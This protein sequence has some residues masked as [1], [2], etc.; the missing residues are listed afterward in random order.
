MV[1]QDEDEEKRARDTALRYLSFR[2]RSCQQVLDRLRYKGF[3][4]PIAEEVV[5]Y[6]KRL[7]YLNDK[8]L[9]LEVAEYLA[10]SKKVGRQYLIHQ[11]RQRGVA[12]EIIEVVSGEMFASDREEKELALQL[13]QKRIAKYRHL[14]VEKRRSRL[15]HLL[16]RHGFCQ[17]TI[18]EV[19]PGVL[20]QVQE[21]NK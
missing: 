10:K 21:E 17:S 6:L 15:F 20:A 18:W 19:L 14:P 2:S 13:L 3:S 1:M 7:N 5:L 16:L 8:R 9:A 4:E 12:E 11:L